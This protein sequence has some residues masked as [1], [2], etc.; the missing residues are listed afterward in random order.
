MRCGQ[1]A[2]GHLPPVQ[3]QVPAISHLNCPWSSEP[4]ATGILGRTVSGDRANAAAAPEPLG[5]GRGAPIGQQVDHPP[6]LKVNQNGPVA[7]A[8]APGPVVHAEHARC[9]SA[10]QRQAA[11]QAQ[12]RRAAG[13][14]AQVI[15][16]ARPGG[17]AERYPNPPLRVGQTTGALCPRGNEARK[18]LHEGLPRT[19]GI[20]AV[21]ASDRQFQAHLPAETRQIGRTAHTAAVDGGT[22]L[23]AIRAA[24]APCPDFS[25]DVEDTSTRP[26][27][28]KD[29]APGQN[30]EV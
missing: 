5:Q 15:Q 23:P 26:G 14:H 3:Q 8:L 29:P 7:P 20:T 4:D 11:H 22:P 6:A 16:Q 30:M 21:K 27:H 1:P 2:L 25:A 9:R 17:A 10:R 13:R 12:H 24:A 28:L 18:P 19:G